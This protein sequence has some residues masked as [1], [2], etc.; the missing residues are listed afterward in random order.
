MRKA[1]THLENLQQL[2][3]LLIPPPPQ[4]PGGGEALPSLG[5]GGQADDG[6]CH[7]PPLS[8]SQETGGGEG[9]GGGR[10]K[11]G[12]IEFACPLGGIFEETGGGAGVIG[13][14]R[15]IGGVRRREREL[16]GE[17]EGESAGVQGE[18]TD[19]GGRAEGEG[20]VGARSEDGV[21]CGVGGVGAGGGGGV[22]GTTLC[23]PQLTKQCRPQFQGLPDGWTQEEDARLG[24]LVCLHANTRRDSEKSVYSE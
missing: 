12:E 6:S 4:Q 14:I 11:E 10:R 24:R 15:G 23:R 21:V 13:S 8:L 19:G 16:G 1:R 20:G 2:Q 17:G 3:P 22:G 18:R 7:G 5:V 9:G